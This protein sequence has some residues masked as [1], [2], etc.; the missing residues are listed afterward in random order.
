[1]VSKRDNQLW[2]EV[3]RVLKPR[4]GWSLQVGSSP[5]APPAWCFGSG[6]EVDLT[7]TVDR[8]AIVL[9]VQE[10]D[11]DIGFETIEDLT[12]WLDANE[13]T[14]LDVAPQAGEIVDDLK[15]GRYLRWRHE[16]E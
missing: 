1:V 3:S 9:Y 8:G 13:A 10:T 16:G 2:D 5:G 4:P 11:K 12:A 15:H 6:G 7:V 14:A